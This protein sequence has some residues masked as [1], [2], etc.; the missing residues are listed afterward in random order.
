MRILVIDDYRP[1]GESLQ[2]VLETRGHEA[3]YAASY[4]EAE[5]Y[6]EVVRFE[7]AFLDFDMPEMKGTAMAAR[8]SERCPAIRSVLI[9]AQPAVAE[10]QARERNLPFLP[11]PVALAD[12]FECLSR[13]EREL[14]GS[15]LMLRPHLPPAPYRKA[16]GR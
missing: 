4:R 14:A 12:L 9:S 2:H 8:L 13:V 10:E 6:L 16:D 15:A 7:L 3:H 1:H 5:G 11:K